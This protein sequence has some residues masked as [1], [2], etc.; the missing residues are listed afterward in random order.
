MSSQNVGC[1]YLQLRAGPVLCCGIIDTGARFSLISSDCYESLPDNC[2]SKI[3][4]VN[5]RLVNADGH[6][7]CVQGK[8][9]VSFLVEGQVFEF[10][11]IVADTLGSLQVIIGIDYL[12]R[13]EMTLLMESSHA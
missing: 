6:N 5:I 4:P 8:A 1:W 13:Y 12:S 10:D 2:K 11:V 9:T 7:L 3:K